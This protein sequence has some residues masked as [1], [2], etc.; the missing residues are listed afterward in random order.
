MTCVPR[1]SVRPDAPV[2][3]A[4]QDK[5]W[6]HWA[7]HTMKLS[8]GYAQPGPMGLNPATAPI[9]FPSYSFSIYIFFLSEHPIGW[10]ILDVSV[11][12]DLKVD[13]LSSVTQTHTNI[14][15]KVRLWHINC[16]HLWNGCLIYKP[17]SCN[18]RSQV[19]ALGRYNLPRAPSA[20][21]DQ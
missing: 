5:S 19:Q 20:Y 2:P 6:A 18:R 8:W 10:F 7:S 11:Q 13:T 14:Y 15:S 21:L 1:K 4:F 12:K 17:I 3:K 9:S 16:Q